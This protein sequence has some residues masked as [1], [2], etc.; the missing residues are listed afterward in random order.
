VRAPT[1]DWIKRAEARTAAIQSS[2]QIAAE[3]LA[4]LGK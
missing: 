4:A 1:Q 3:A 2:N